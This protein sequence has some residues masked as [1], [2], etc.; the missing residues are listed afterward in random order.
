LK[1]N[2]RLEARQFGLANPR[3]KFETGNP[4]GLRG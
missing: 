2:F 4:L 1:L 3:W